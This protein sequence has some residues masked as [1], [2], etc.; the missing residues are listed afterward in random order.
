[1]PYRPPSSLYL[2]ITRQTSVP[3]SWFSYFFKRSA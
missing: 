1:M 2:Q 3:S